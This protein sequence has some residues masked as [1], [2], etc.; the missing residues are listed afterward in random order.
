MEAAL[1]EIKKLETTLA[2][3]GEDGRQPLILALTKVI[4]SLE[5]ADD[6]VQRI[7]GLVSHIEDLFRR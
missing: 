1:S 3:V 2:Q 4:L 7:G 5:S 6:M